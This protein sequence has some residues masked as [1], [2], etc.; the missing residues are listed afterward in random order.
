MFDS[1]L[2]VLYDAADPLDDHTPSFPGDT[3]FQRQ[4]LPDQHPWQVSSVAMS[5]HS[6]THL[7]APLHRIPGGLAIDALPLERLIGPGQVLEIGRAHVLTPV[8]L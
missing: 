2:P 6:G 7:D 8:T 5:S 1:A 4:P 3:R